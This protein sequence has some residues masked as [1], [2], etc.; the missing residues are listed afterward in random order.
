MRKCS[1]NLGI[2]NNGIAI[3]YDWTAQLHLSNQ[4][5]ERETT[6]KKNWTIIT[7]RERKTIKSEEEWCTERKKYKTAD[8]RRWHRARQRANSIPNGKTEATRSN[9]N[10]QKDSWREN[11]NKNKRDEWEPKDKKRSIKRELGL[12]KT[13]TS[14][15]SLPAF[16][17]L[18]NRRDETNTTS[19]RAFLHL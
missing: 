12:L 11:K 17:C 5:G 13:K 10:G 14:N 15:V 6:R 19:E 7:G 16:R 1:C 3:P 2:C 4:A 8:I 18:K 9:E